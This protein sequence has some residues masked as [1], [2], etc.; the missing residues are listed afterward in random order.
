MFVRQ[1][2]LSGEVWRDMAP[3]SRRWLVIFPLLMTV[4]I[5][6]VLLSRGLSDA[7]AS[8][9]IGIGG[10][11]ALV[12]LTEEL[13]FRGILLVGSRQLLGSERRAVLTSSLLFGLFHLPNVFTGQPLAATLNQVISTTVLGMAFYCL[14]RV[15][16][17]LWPAVVLH[18]A[19]DFALLQSMF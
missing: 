10:T 14:R 19:Y 5:V 17:R 13:S 12:G 2:H 3:T 11:M 7:P 4:G 16:A 15:T 8:Y 6:G 18:A 1:F 9:W